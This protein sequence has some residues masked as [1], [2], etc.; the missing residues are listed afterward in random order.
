[1]LL[2]ALHYSSLPG[3]FDSIGAYDY[4]EVLLLIDTDVLALADPTLCG[5]LQDM[6]RVAVVG[7][8]IDLE[9]CSAKD[10]EMYEVLMQTI[11][12][13]C[14]CITVMQKETVH[15]AAT[16]AK[17]HSDLDRMHSD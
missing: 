13:G 17:I 1:M 10:A 9:N 12:A 15:L 5:W 16:V 11:E 2:I 8:T 14:S 7:D 6:R 4:A 3:K